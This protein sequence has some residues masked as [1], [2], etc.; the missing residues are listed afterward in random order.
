MGLCA[1]LQTV[2]F[3]HRVGWPRGEQYIVIEST[4]SEQCFSTMLLNA[5]TKDPTCEK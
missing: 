1:K 3:A 2:S 4:V 5:C